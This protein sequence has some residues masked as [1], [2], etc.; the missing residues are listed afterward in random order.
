MLGITFIT[1]LVLY[2]MW[3][4]WCGGDRFGY[5][6]LTEWTPITTVLSYIFFKPLVLKKAMKIVLIILIA[7]SLYVQ[8]NAVW[9][10]KSRCSGATHNWTLYCLQPQFIN[11][12]EY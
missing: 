1:M 8:F 3:H 10:R 2:S 11:P 12:Q 5:G 4:D 7:W 9:F 6:F